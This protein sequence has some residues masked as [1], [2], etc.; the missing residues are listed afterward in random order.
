MFIITLYSDRNGGRCYYPFTNIKYLD[1]LNTKQFKAY[2]T[3]IIMYADNGES[4][5]SS[6]S[7]IFWPISYDQQIVWKLPHHS[8][9]VYFFLNQSGIYIS[10]NINKRICMCN[11]IK[12]ILTYAE[13]LYYKV[14]M[15]KKKKILFSKASLKFSLLLECTNFHLCIKACIHYYFSVPTV[16]SRQSQMN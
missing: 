11:K 16:N 12:L 8:G 13:L 14:P 5:I 10:M 15:V 7:I 6:R 9:D 2:T 4:N 3:K 1:I